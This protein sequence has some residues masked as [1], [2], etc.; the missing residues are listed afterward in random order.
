[1]SPNLSGDYRHKAATIHLY[2]VP[3]AKGKPMVTL[4]CE[5]CQQIVTF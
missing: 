3:C 2:W 4:I 5:Q 1:L